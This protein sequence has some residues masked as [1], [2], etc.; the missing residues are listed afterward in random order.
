M[1]RKSQEQFSF[2]EIHFVKSDINLAHSCTSGRQ[3]FELK[4]VERLENM[5]IQFLVKKKYKIAYAK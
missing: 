5:F 3:K 1:E 4:A 2:S